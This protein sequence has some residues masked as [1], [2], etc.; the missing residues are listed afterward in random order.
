MAELA[1]VTGAYGFLGRHVARALAAKGVNVIGIGHGSWGRDEWRRWGIA[2]WHAEE[3]TVETLT[4]HVHECDM[5][6]HCAGS[7]SV[8]FSM[9]HPYQD[10]KRTV[11]S[12]LA[13]LEC[14]R[15]QWPHSRL[16]IPSSAG[17][18]GMTAGTPIAIDH[19]LLPVSPY[20]VHKKMAEDLCRS[21][22]QHF[23][24][25]SSIVRLFSVFGIGI[26]KQLLWDA[27]SKL[28]RGDGIFNGTGQEIRDWLHVEDAAQLMLV[29]A[30]NASVSCPVVNGGTGH[31]VCIRN[32]VELVAQ[33]LQSRV[34]PRFSGHSRA[35]DPTYYQA[36]ISSAR[37]WG[38]SPQRDCVSEMK[39][40]VDWFQDG[41]P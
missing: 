12:T 9:S 1:L 39:A 5:V 28:S 8:A 13:V 35:G 21:Y 24:V 30:H 7:S 26:R 3:V 6:F 32:V 36:D 18:Y 4:T 23:G 38:W 25:R 2:E 22:A 29:A 41:A 34:S 16:V 40:Y 27:C 31:V 20:G 15:T 14:L 33:R 10:W 37:A 19:A 17:V 11:D